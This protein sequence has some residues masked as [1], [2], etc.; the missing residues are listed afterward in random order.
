M[1]TRKPNKLKFLEFTRICDYSKFRQGRVGKI[2]GF[3][4]WVQNLTVE[5]RTTLS[6]YGN[7]KFYVSRSEDPKEPEYDV[8]FLGNECFEV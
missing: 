6:R 2:C 3:F 8:V 7:T 1:F 4:F 5:K